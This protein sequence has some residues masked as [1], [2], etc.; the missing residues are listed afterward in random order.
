MWKHLRL[1]VRNKKGG[2][3][4][5]GVGFCWKVVEAA[6]NWSYLK[7]LFSGS[8]GHTV[9]Q[10]ITRPPMAM[11]IFGLLWVLLAD[12][13]ESRK[14]KPAPAERNVIAEEIRAGLETGDELF[15]HVEKHGEY[16]TF[17]LI[18]TGRREPPIVPKRNKR[19][20]GD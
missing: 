6:H 18:K 5:A 11:L 9:L 8:V 20:L 7:E 4:M 12:R 15:L 19:L 16:H 10:Q 17:T 14:D 3:I 1:I 2:L 13:R